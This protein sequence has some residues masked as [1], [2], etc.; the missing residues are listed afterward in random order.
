MREPEE[1]LEEVETPTKPAFRSPIPY[2]LGSS[3]EVVSRI[4]VIGRRT[5]L[6]I[7]S[8]KLVQAVLQNGGS[9]V[10]FELQVFEKLTIALKEPNVSRVLNLTEQ[11]RKQ[12]LAD[13]DLIKPLLRSMTDKLRDL[14]LEDD[15]IE[16]GHIEQQVYDCSCGLQS[17][18]D[19]LLHFTNDYV[20]YAHQLI[21]RRGETNFAQG[22][23]SISTRDGRERGPDYEYR[24]DK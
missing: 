4:K 5:E 13:S 14:D 19:K 15:D 18:R 23:S 11:S 24:L 2:G 16:L 8:A 12:C 10:N 22:Y 20:R 3:S 1:K 7:N 9:S 17:V 21:P 6:L